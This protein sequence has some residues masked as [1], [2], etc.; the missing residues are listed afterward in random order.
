M[1]PL[2]IMIMLEPCHVTCF[3]DLIEHGG[4]VYGGGA[5][6]LTDGVHAQ[7]WHAKVARPQPKLG[8]HHWTNG[9][10]TGTV[11]ADH[12][13]LDNVI[14]VCVAVKGGGAC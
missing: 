9:G 1:P 4:L 12:N 14:K 6:H 5:A 8:R 2:L 13:F 3:A 10:A 7:L 11:V